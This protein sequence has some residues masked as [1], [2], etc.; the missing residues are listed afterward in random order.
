[1]SRSNRRWGFVSFKQRAEG[2]WLPS[3]KRGTSIC[4]CWNSKLNTCSHKRLKMHRIQNQ[5]WCNSFFHYFCVSVSVCS[6]PVNKIIH[7]FPCLAPQGDLTGSRA[8]SPLPWFPPQ[9]FLINLRH[10]TPCIR[11]V[12]L[13]GILFPAAWNCILSLVSVAKQSSSL[14]ASHFQ[15]YYRV[16]S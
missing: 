2:L 16:T 12:C 3:C 9:L 11:Q 1:M 7:F 8:L 10:S 6:Q 14:T 13:S 5:F 15:A 4:S